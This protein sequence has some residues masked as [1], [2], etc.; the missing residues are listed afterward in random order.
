MYIKK[1]INLAPHN[2][3]GIDCRATL[4]TTITS[5][6]DVEEVFK[7]IPENFLILGGGSNILFTKDFDGLVIKNEIMGIDILSES[8]T[9]IKVNV[10]AGEN[11][12]EFVLKAVENKWAGIENL[13]LIPGTVGAAPI[14]NI[15]AYG[16]EAKDVIEE[17]IFF[18]IETGKF[19]SLKS[20]ACDFGYRD[21]VFKNQLKGKILICSVTFKLNK[22]FVPHTSYGAIE[23]ILKSKSITTPSIKDVSDAVIAIR[24]SK[25]PDPEEIGNAGSFFK[26]PV[27]PNTTF[28]QLLKKFP[29]IPHYKVNENETKIPAG[30][31]IQEAGWK[32]RRFEHIGIHPKQ[33]LV[34]VNYGGGKG[35]EIKQLALDI[36]EDIYEKFGIEISPEVNMI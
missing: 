19:E 31:L 2:T 22:S 6:E 32:G 7:T 34:L 12:H 29:D 5:K 11:W 1:D 18:N 14:Q 8:E 4:F 33:A 17:V 3:F 21:S 23:E 10:G 24:Q 9:H 25:L 13:S 27:I 36:K 15:G 26:N 28:D 20:D 30:W 16:I 35:K